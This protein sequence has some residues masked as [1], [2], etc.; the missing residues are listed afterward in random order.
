VA[1]EEINPFLV[2]DYGD[3]YDR[4]MRVVF[5]GRYKLITTSR[6]EKLLFDLTVDP[7]EQHDIAPSE[8]ERVEAMANQLEAV[9]ESR[10][11]AAERSKQVN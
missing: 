7:R 5:D 11:A 10:V 4:A 8:P 3:V 6:G 2:K 9:T 1:E